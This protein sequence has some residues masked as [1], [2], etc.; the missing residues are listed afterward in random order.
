MTGSERDNSGAKR[1]KRP[2]AAREGGPSAPFG[3]AEWRRMKE[4]LEYS[5]TL[6]RTQQECALDGILVVSEDGRIV[7]YNI[8]AAAG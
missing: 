2:P 6:M 3:E 4:E 5:N 1:E 8:L 7:S